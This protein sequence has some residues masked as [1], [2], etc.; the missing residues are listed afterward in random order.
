M[1]ETDSLP[2]EVLAGK[3]DEYERNCKYS[4]S[5]ATIDDAIAAYDKVD[6]YP[7]CYMTYRGRVIEVCRR[8]FKIFDH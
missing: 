3:Y 1:T 5:F 6:C 4:E 2:F 8:D 7:W